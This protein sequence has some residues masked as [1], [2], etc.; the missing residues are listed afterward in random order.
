[1]VGAWESR[2]GR[3]LACRSV[4][5]PPRSFRQRLQRE[6]GELAAQ[7]SRA[8]GLAR[9]PPPS[10]LSTQEEDQVVEHLC[11]ERF[12]DVGVAEAWATLLDEGTY[13]C[14][15][16]T[17]H[18]VLKDRGLSGERRQSGQRGHHPKPRVVASAPN[19][20]WVWDIT[21]I[22]GPHK[23]AWFYLYSV[24]DLWSRMTVGWTVS[25]EETSEVA[26]ELMKVTARRQGVRRHE[27][28]IHSDR[29]A[30]MTAGNIAE[31]YD[32]LGVRRSLSRP[33]VSNDNPHAEAQFKTLKYR[34][35]WLARFDTVQDVVEHCDKFFGW[36]N[37]KHHHS[38]IGLVTPAQRHAGNGQLVDRLRQEVLDAA[39]E[40]HPERF[41]NGRPKPPHQPSLV[42][43]N[44]PK[45]HSK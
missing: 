37:H 28:I 40:S 18:R 24:M 39:F 33:R 15:L 31:L 41:P 16:R 34:P 7:P 45:K 26:E 17:M 13:I 36:Y 35:D 23:G 10:K 20:V 27:L 4:G 3:E 21:R 8:T 30:Q 6:R 5:I 2:V 11:S 14:S 29:G 32:S 43:I 42:W 38:G 1:M 22:P 19:M 9:K 25:T 12:C 44:P